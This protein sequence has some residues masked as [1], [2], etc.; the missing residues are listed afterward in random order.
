M[1]ISM[2]SS[3]R[4]TKHGK[5]FLLELLGAGD[6]RLSPSFFTE[7]MAHLETVNNSEDAGALVTTNEGKFFCNGLDLEWISENIKERGPVLYRKFEELLIALM[8]MKVPTIAAV[9]GH[10][11][12]GGFCLAMAHDHRFMRADRGF[13]YSSGVDINVAVPPGTLALFACKMSPRIYKDAVLKC[14]K[15]TGKM[16]LE[17]DLIDGLCDDPETTLQEAL[18]EAEALAGRNWE[19]DVYKGMRLAMYPDVLEKLRVGDYRTFAPTGASL[20]GFKP[21]Q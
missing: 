11:A 7:I 4:L 8:C 20:K 9:C 15:Y 16:A 5:V 10:A 13:L 19:K 3:S 17:A 6:H 12:G 18:K 14:V 21:Q 1:S 2:G